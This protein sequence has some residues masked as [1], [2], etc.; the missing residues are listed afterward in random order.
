MELNFECLKFDYI[1]VIFCYIKADVLVDVEC[2]ARRLDKVLQMLNREVQSVN[3]TTIHPMS[4][5]P[6]LSACSSFGR[7]QSFY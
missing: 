1:L 6:S 7:I 2:D 4:R 3:Y 5:A